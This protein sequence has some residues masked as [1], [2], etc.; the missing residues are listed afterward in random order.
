MAKAAGRGPIII[1][2][3]DRRLSEPNWIQDYFPGVWQTALGM[4]PPLSTRIAQLHKATDREVSV[5][6]F[7]VPRDMNDLFFGAG[8]HTPRL[9]IK[10]EFLKNISTFAWSDRNHV[11]QGL[12]C[13]SSDLETGRWQQQ[14]RGLDQRQEIDFGYRFLVAV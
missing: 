7:P 4:Y 11:R 2:T 6:P 12:E 14:Y 13:L 5:F 8:W 1:F 9:Y 3:A 10:P